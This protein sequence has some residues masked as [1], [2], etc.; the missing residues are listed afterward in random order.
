MRHGIRIALVGL[1]MLVLAGSISLAMRDSGFIKA[2]ASPYELVVF[3]RETCNYCDLFRRDVAPHYGR[4][5][6]AI[7]APLRFVDIDKT[8]LAKLHLI[9]PL[10]VLPT[11][12]LMKNG[13]EVA[14]IPGMTAASTFSQLVHVMVARAK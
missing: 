11:T 2:A 3:Q 9:T 8:D 1:G 14:R 4:D 13:A 5:P 7:E 6:I 10:T 12:V